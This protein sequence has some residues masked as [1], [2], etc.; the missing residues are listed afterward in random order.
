[1]SWVIFAAERIGEQTL[2]LPLFPAMTGDDLERVCGAFA[3]LLK[4]GAP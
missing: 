4:G 2:T 1:M 3:Q